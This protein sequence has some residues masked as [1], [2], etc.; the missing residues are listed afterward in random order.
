M[1]KPSVIHKQGNGTLSDAHPSCVQ[2]CCSDCS[3]AEVEFAKTCALRQEKFD[4]IKL[5]P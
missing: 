5:N 4:R 2:N 1:K 3:V